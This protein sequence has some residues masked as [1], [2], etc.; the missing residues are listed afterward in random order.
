MVS[1]ADG[2]QQLQEMQLVHGYQSSVEPCLIFGIGKRNSV[3]IKIIWPN[4]KMQELTQQ[5][6]NK[7]ITVEEKMQPEIISKKQG[8]KCCLQKWQRT[9]L[10]FLIAKMIS[11]TLKGNRFYPIIFQ[12]TALHLQREM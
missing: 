2:F 5:P 3:N 8:R 11:T 12:K 6:V 9:I 10:L 1:A 4:G 7:L